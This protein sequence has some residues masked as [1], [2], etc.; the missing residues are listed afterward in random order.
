MCNDKTKKEYLPQ[1]YDPFINGP[2]RGRIKKLFSLS[3]KNKN[4]IYIKNYIE[5][6][7][8]NKIHSILL[9]INRLE[10]EQKLN[11]FDR[12]ACA[13]QVYYLLNLINEFALKS[14]SSFNFTRLT[15]HEQVRIDS[16]D[17][18]KILKFLFDTDTTLPNEKTIYKEYIALKEIHKKIPK[19]G[20]AHV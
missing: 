14:T 15:E 7:L 9:I 12:K 1:L 5:K 19:I 16:E 18:I 3:I 11:L 6:F 17:R 4:E 8:I 10:F 20:R 13:K 2:Y